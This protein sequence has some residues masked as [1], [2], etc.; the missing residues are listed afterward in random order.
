[1]LLTTVAFSELSFPMTYVAVPHY[2][3]RSIKDIEYLLAYEDKRFGLILALTPR[4][5]PSCRAIGRSGPGDFWCL[6]HYYASCSSFRTKTE[7]ADVENIEVIRATQLELMFSKKNSFHLS[8]PAPY[9]GNIEGIKSELIY[10]N[11]Q[12]N[13]LT[14]SEAALLVALPQSPSRT[15][16][17]RIFR[18][19][20]SRI[21]FCTALELKNYL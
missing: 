6:N 16:Q 17:T 2:T 18:T 8:D 12:P 21:K 19:K 20:C 10:F 5:D 7:N 15:G 11:K 13:K 14:V 9:G 3:V 1:M 4:S